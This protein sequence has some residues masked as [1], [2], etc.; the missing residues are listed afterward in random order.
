M[1]MSTTPPRQIHIFEALGAPIPV[2]A[3][4]PTVLNEQGEKLSKRHGAKAV[5]QYR[6]ESYLADAMINY[7]SRLVQPHAERIWY[8]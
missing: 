2:F 4:L 6:D 8:I 5:T 1:T 7:I 3:H